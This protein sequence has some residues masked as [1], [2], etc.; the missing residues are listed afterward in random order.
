MSDRW[1]DESWRRWEREG[2]DPSR[3]GQEWDNRQVPGRPGMEQGHP[4]RD[5]QAEPYRGDQRPGNAGGWSG[6]QEG[7]GRDERG[8]VR[9]D[10]W[11]DHAP[12]RGY[13]RSTYQ[14]PGYGGAGDVGWDHR[15]AGYR[16]RDANWSGPGYGQGGREAA[17]RDDDRW[18]DGDRGFV[19]RAADEVASWFGDDDAERRRREDEG[20]D[21]RRWRGRDW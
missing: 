2:R 18:R 21:R 4:G 15:A 7:P 6:S 1:R 9:G 10:D 20:N 5:R 11:R 13:G 8:R 3:V 16:D 12:R 17:G 14:D 19:D